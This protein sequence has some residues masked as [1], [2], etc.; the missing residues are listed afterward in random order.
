M[1]KQYIAPT[2]EVERT[3]CCSPLCVSFNGNNSEGNDQLG[4]GRNSGY[5]EDDDPSSRL[6]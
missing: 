1:K 4:K 2:L 6:W 5:E 3:Q